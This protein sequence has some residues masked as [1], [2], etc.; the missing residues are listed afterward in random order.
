MDR[1][2]YA[3]KIALVILAIAVAGITSGMG[4]TQVSHAVAHARYSA[5]AEVEATAWR[6]AAW[7]AHTVSNLIQ[8]EIIAP[9]ST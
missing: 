8:V 9:L 5:P 6:A 3:V 7:I 4:T 2:Y 1:R